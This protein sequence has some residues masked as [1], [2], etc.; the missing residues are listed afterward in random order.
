MIHSLS[1]LIYNFS[2]VEVEKQQRS[3]FSWEAMRSFEALVIVRGSNIKRHRKVKIISG[4][5]G[6]GSVC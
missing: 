4:F 6:R 1:C 2:S 5:Q 3:R